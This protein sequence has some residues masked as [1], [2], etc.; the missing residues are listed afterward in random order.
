MAGFR[1]LAEYEAPLARGYDLLPFRFHRLRDGTVFVSNLVGD[2]ETLPPDTFEAFTGRRL[3][4][5]STAYADLKGKH[6]LIDADSS[7][8]FDL[9]A[10]KMRTRLSH[11]RHFLGLAIFVVT[12][13]CEHSCP[14][15]QVSRQSDDRVA[16][17]MTKETAEKALDLLFESPA[18]EFK[19]EFQG[20]EPLLNFEL[21]TEIVS[22]AKARA[23]RTG[24]RVSFV[25]ATNLALLNDE[26]LAFCKEHGVLLSTSLDG[27]ADLHNKNRPRRGNNSHELAV[28]GMQRAR[29]VLGPDGVAALMTTTKASLSRPKEIIDEYRRLGLHE[30]FLRPLSPYGFAI[31][32]KS[33]RAYQADEWLDF[34]REGL[35][36]I[37]DLNKAGERMT[38]LYAATILRKMLTP[39]PGSYVD[40]MNPAGIG[41]QVLVFNYDGDVYASDEAR[42]L[43]EMGDKTFRLGNVHTD[44]L[45]AMLTGDALMDA[46]EHTVLESVPMCADCAFQPYC[47]ADPVYHHATQGDVVGHKPT[48]GFCKRQTAIFEDLIDIMRTDPEAARIFRSWVAF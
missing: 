11:L 48:S 21:I 9:L 31:K 6:F 14:Y 22:L 34:Y 30:I 7:V 23:E 47:G 40:M 8:A 39:F 42:M 25:I 16:F 1:S 19:I 26:V 24:K 36:Y 37:L 2:W 5:R 18:T 20:G 15:C 4:P 32:T 27:P 3:D 33:Y 10:L 45:D 43:A 28:K 12:L 38:E 46:V 35:Q 44:T 41:T 13:R 29:E 17:D